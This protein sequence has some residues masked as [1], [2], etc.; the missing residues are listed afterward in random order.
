MEAEAAD[1]IQIG[2]PICGNYKTFFNQCIAHL[3][4]FTYFFKFQK[5][6]EFPLS[7]N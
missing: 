3:I 7:G 5:I 1:D 4:D 6:S 2:L